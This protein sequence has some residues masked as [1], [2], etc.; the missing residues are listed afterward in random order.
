MESVRAEL[1]V[2]R[3]SNHEDPGFL[4]SIHIPMIPSLEF[5]K[6]AVGWQLRVWVPRS[7]T[8]I[9]EI[10]REAISL[11]RRDLVRVSGMLSGHTE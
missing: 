8:D 1:D 7:L 4:V 11:L 6:H 3:V 10:Q 9:R 2:L 5:P